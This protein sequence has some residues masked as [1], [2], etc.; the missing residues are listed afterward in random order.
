MMDLLPEWAPNIHPLLVHFP[1]A[2]LI[3]AVVIDLLALLLRKEIWLRNTRLLVYLLGSL[4]AVAAY[5][6]GSQAADLVSLPPLANPVLTEHADLALLTIIY[7]LLYTLIS[8]ILFIKEIDKSLWVQFIS[9]VL[10]F[11]GI[12]LL[13]ETAEH[14]AELVYRFGAGVTKIESAY[15]GSHDEDIS[16]VT[17]ILEDEN[18]SW[19]W[20]P[21]ESAEKILRSN[22][23]WIRGKTENLNAN[24]VSDS[25][26]G[27]ILVLYVEKDLIMLERGKDLRSIQANMM[28]NLDR[29]DG[30]FC[31][32]HHVEDSLNYDFL[33]IKNDRM[34]LGRVL[35]NQLTIMDQKPF[36]LGNWIK[37]SVV[38]D[39][40]H[41]RG[42]IDDKLLTHGHDSELQPGP[43]GILIDGKGEILVDWIE[44]ISLK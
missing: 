6:S 13:F 24:I 21:G 26:R 30:K 38:G 41:F 39:G 10:V 7:F 14:G 20:N 2:L 19:N 23:N 9:V 35:H 8:S 32:I 17:Q 4:S 3:I 29:F 36:T 34:Q 5:L 15:V 33:S 22:F 25:I 37:V 12:F 43:V 27:L 31:I 18:G 16:A 28:I 42:F 44:V 1:I 11:P 40:T